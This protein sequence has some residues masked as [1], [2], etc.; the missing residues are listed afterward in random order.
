[1]LPR[2][3]HQQSTSLLIPKKYNLLDID[4]PVLEKILSYL[5]QNQ[6]SN[7]HLH[8]DTISIASSCKTFRQVVANMLTNDAFWTVNHTTFF[9][10]DKVTTC[11]SLS[12][13]IYEEPC[14]PSIQNVLNCRRKPCSFIHEQLVWYNLAGSNLRT[15]HLSSL[16]RHVPS[17]EIVHI[18]QSLTNLA[19]PLRNL[20]L[21]CPLHVN[22][23][24]QADILPA[25]QQLVPHIAPTLVN[26][27]F[28]TEYSILAQ[29][30]CSD[31]L[32]SLKQLSL[33]FHSGSPHPSRHVTNDISVSYQLL[34][35]CFESGANLDTLS[36]Y[37]HAKH[38]E[39]LHNLSVYPNVE[40]LSLHP[41]EKGLKM[42]FPLPRDMIKFKIQ[43]LHIHNA[44]IDD[45]EMERI[46]HFVATTESLSELHLHTCRTW[47]L[48]KALELYPLGLGKKL[49]TLD[50]FHDNR[51]QPVW[52]AELLET[53][54]KYCVNLKSLRLRIL[55]EDALCSVGTALVKLKTL[56][57]LHLDSHSMIGSE[58]QGIE[59][60][61]LGARKSASPIEQISFKNISIG[62][63]H[64]CELLDHFSDT[65]QQLNVG[66][67]SYYMGC[68][69]RSLRKYNDV[70]HVFA[71]ALRYRD[72]YSKLNMLKLPDYIFLQ[73][74]K[75][76]DEDKVM[77]EVEMLKSKLI[78]QSVQV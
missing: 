8:K 44:F 29:A 57:I 47:W 7:Y 46:A 78:V 56:Q 38:V 14:K 2:Q 39:H 48:N 60:L 30:I 33:R 17:R 23:Q 69:N 19:V 70:R 45:R 63:D 49:I 51:R 71:H 4:S 73:M 24:K 34:K 59:D 28:H 10:N 42:G 13:D 77:E 21:F 74:E 3:S 37:C 43:Q 65:I 72:R 12:N 26:L 67:L 40:K 25:L 62:H 27:S 1:M 5:C 64:V 35:H 18:L 36:L 55:H 20:N 61:M 52:N 9:N 22:A 41:T 16:L 15:F 53:V 6:P 76:E 75:D 54:S 32:P 50:F 11:S 66:F 68:V 31:P 58:K